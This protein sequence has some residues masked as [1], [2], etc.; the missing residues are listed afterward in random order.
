MIKHNLTKLKNL[1]SLHADFFNRLCRRA[2]VWIRRLNHVSHPIKT[3]M[4]YFVAIHW[5]AATLGLVA[6]QIHHF[7]RCPPE[8]PAYVYIAATLPVDVASREV[9]S[10]NRTAICSSHA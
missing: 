2:E 7:R 5:L 8:K 10:L 4:W 1:S 6:P 3:L 9:A